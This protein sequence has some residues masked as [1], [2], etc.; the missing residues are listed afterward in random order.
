MTL[1]TPPPSAQPVTAR[2]CLAAVLALVAGA[3][4]PLAFAPFFSD[5]PLCGAALAVVLLT[6]LLGLWEGA[7]PAQAAVRGGL[8][9]IGAYGVGISWVFISLH[10]YGHA[11]LLF[12]GITTTL[13]VALM[14]LYPAVMGYLVARYAPTGVVYRVVIWIPALW[15]FLEW[16]RSWLFTGFP[17]LALGYSQIDSPLAGFA[18]YGGVFAVSFAVMVSAGLLYLVLY[19]TCYPRLGW[20]VAFALLWLAAGGLSRIEWVSATGTPLRISL[21]QGNIAQDQ[22]F[23]PDQLDRTLQRYTQLSMQATPHS[24][25]I[26]WPETA[27]PI[28]YDDARSLIEALSDHARQNQVDYLIGVPSGSW[29]SGVFHNSVISIGQVPGF[30]HKHRLLPFGEYIPLRALLGFFHD[31][32]E[33]P[34]ADFTPGNRYQP[35]LQSA[36]QPVGVSICFEAVFGSEIRRSLPTAHWLVNVSNDAWFGHSLAPY[37]HLQIARMRA[38]EAGR[39]L[40][41]ATNT[42][43]SAV[44]NER[45]HVLTRAPFNHTAVI[46]QTV[47]P[48]QGATP[49]VRWGDD[50]VVVGCVLLVLLGGLFRPR[51]A[52]TEAASAVAIPHDTTDPLP[53]APDV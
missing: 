26:I 18:P 22:K 46:R 31:W 27:I 45:G 51:I 15:V 28:L 1:V 38:L 32:V 6:V 34:M 19:S 39:Y 5:Y 49:Y 25:V 53:T 20:I 33:I 8:F 16:V 41:R 37:Q 43:I 29:D 9:G 35:L 30:Y 12:A 40:V 14:A 3:L 48:L 23:R 42:G 24:D 47:R 11:P 52:G 2:H 4:L 10:H 7:S 36:G 44:I 21:I 17:W 13:L 50:P